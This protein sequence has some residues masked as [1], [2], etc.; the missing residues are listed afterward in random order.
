LG[1]VCFILLGFIFGL[2]MNQPY[3]LLLAGQRL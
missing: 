2:G 3:C 1:L